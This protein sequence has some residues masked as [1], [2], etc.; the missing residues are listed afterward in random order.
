MR[1]RSLLS[2]KTLFSSFSFA[3]MA[4]SAGSPA[5]VTLLSPDQAIVVKVQFDTRPDAGVAGVSYTVSFHG[6]PV[7]LASKLGLT[8]QEA[9]V[10][11]AP[12]T[13]GKPSWRQI[14]ETRT[15]SS[16]ESPR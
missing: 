15:R 12:L 2:L 7:V 4:F 1:P 6:R 13:I 14:D 5:P 3:A 11:G 16:T 8:I 9:P 10:F